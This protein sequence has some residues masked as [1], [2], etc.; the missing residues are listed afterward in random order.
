M[1]KKMW[2]GKN[3]KKEY[4]RGENCQGD[5]QQ[6]NFL[7]SWIKDI[8]YDLAKWLSYYLIFLFIFFLFSF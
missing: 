6:G 7:G 2:Q 5:L 1:T 4:L 3:E 8:C